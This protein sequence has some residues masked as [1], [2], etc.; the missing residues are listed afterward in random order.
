MLQSAIEHIQLKEEHKREEERM[1][2]EFKKR[3]LE[4]FAE[5]ERLEQYNAQKRRMK[6]IEF[7]KEVYT[8]II[9]IT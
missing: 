5:D 6:E 8:S 2:N 1:E 9:I 7:K 4:K 3:L